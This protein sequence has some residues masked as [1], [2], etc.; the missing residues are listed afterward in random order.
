M[1][2]PLL[3]HEDIDDE[4]EP[5]PMREVTAYGETVTMPAEVAD[6]WDSS[7]WRSSL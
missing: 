6:Q 5:Q 3:T 4:S 7:L 2:D 1:T